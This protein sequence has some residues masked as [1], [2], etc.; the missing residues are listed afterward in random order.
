M[1]KDLFPLLIKMEMLNELGLQDIL[2]VMESAV[3]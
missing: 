1:T 3:K 2:R